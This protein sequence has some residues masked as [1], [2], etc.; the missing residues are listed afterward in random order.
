MATG[1]SELAARDVPEKRMEKVT[2]NAA[3][4]REITRVTSEHAYCPYHTFQ[5]CFITPP[6]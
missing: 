1:R 6:F 3:E 2:G 5:A 4:L